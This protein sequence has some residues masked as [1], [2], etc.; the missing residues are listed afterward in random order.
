[1]SFENCKIINTEDNKYN[2]LNNNYSEANNNVD[3]NNHYYNNG[4]AN[5]YHHCHNQIP[6]LIA[7]IERRQADID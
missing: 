6:F 5:Y 3:N 4:K 7:Y 1:M 2:S